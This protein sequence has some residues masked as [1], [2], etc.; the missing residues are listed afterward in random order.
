MLPS[1][2]LRLKLV[3]F[4]RHTSR[5]NQSDL[6]RPKNGNSG[7]CHSDTPGFR[8]PAW[9]DVTC[10]GWQVAFRCFGEGD[11]C[12]LGTFSRRRRSISPTQE[13]ADRQ[14]ASVLSTCAISRVSLARSGQALLAQFGTE[15][16][17]TQECA[18][19][20]RCGLST[21]AFGLL[22]RI[23][24]QPLGASP[25]LLQSSHK[26]DASAFRLICAVFWAR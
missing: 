7:C 12:T 23:I 10:A 15:E 22:A 20:A 21:N 14:S 4:V 13:N 5:T 25:R 11:L 9:V 17:A 1:K 19:D 18:T 6:P 16:L 24:H 26:P 8:Q 3:P 2:Q